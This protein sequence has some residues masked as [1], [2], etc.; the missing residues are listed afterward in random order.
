MP[1]RE[2]SN[3]SRE[4][5]EA[6]VWRL[7]ERVRTGSID[8]ARQNAVFE[9]ALDFAIVVTDREGT[10]TDWNSGSEHVMGW[11]AE[12]MRGQDAARFFTPEDRANGRV[13][14]EMET[15]LKNGRAQDER[16][17]LKQGEERF[18]ASGEMMPLRDDD[19]RHIGFVK[20]MR[21]RTAEHMAG[22]A[23]RAGELRR[24]ALLE[25]SDQ[26]AEHDRDTASLADVASGI[27]GRALGVQ[28][29]GYG[30]VDP[31][32]ETIDVERDWT[33]DGAHS[34]AGSL[35]FRDF[36]SYIDDIKRGETVVIGDARIDPRTSA[37]ADALEAISARAF[38]NTPVVEHGRLVSLLF[39]CSATPRK[40]TKDEL[41][42]I[43]EVAA[44]TRTATARKQAESAL[45]AREAELRLVADA[46]PVLVAFIDRTLTYRFVNAACQWWFGRAPDT[47]VGRTI[48]DLL[49]ES[50]L[51]E[52]RAGIER[53][54]AGET[55]QMDLDWP[56]SDGRR[57]IAAIRYTPRRDASGSVD[58]F[59]VFAQDVTDLRDATAL[60]A[61]RADTLAHEVAERT[62]ERDRMWET[63]PDLMLEI[64]FDG[65]FQRVNPAWTRLLGYAPDELVGHHVNEFVLPADHTETTGA[66]TQAA[67][68]GQPRL[69]N[70]YRHKNGSVRWISWSAAPAGRMTY[71]T[72]R[73]ITAEREQ[74]QALE[75]TA[76]ALRQSQKMEAVGQ[77]TGGVA[78]DFNNLLTII[79]SS[80]DFLRRPNLPEERRKRY[81]DAVS[82]TVE[83][84]AKLT[85]QLLAFAR[86]QALKPEVL[87]VGERLRAVADMLDTVTGARVRVVTEL[88]DHPCFIEADVSQFETAL[89]N[90]A[91]NA[92][93]AM[94]GEGT[95]TLRLTCGLPMPPIRGHG[96][97]PGP[98]AKIELS[99]T[100]SGIAEVDLARIFEPFFTTKEVGKGTGLGLSQVFGFAKQSGG[101]VSVRS[102]VGEGT[103]FALYLPEVAAPVDQAN[104]LE[105]TSPAPDGRGLSVLVV[106]DNIE[107]G[108]FATQIL[109][110]LGY[111]TEWAAN[112]EAALER[113]GRDGDGFDAVFSDVV[114]PG[115][116]GIAMAEE[117]RR[118]LPTMPVLLASGY[119]HVLAQN[120]THGFELLHKPYSADQLSRMLRRLIHSH[121]RRR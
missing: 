107:V 57:R 110:D 8:A 56:W 71:A 10:I 121:Q 18:W 48:D 66:Y 36:G 7:R 61:A 72:G 103:T 34:I 15:A 112:A 102:V 95:L 6:E 67:E 91:V 92:R 43:R 98:F 49:G 88:P 24:Q 11:T 37:H 77:L 59:Y 106:E 4:E 38:V 97:G 115:I 51:A 21:D 41:L 90:M 46:L 33:T 39:V 3:L 94:E 5:L 47:V 55:V 19:D 35:R 114:M 29:V 119:S 104:D 93:D 14:Y 31:E 22:V 60:L 113:L 40:W 101:D 28:L 111:R 9:S 26:L 30:L 27:L 81:M 96:G 86:R 42:F 109:E 108:K 53:A 45:L 75:A 12:E 82:D 85:G 74:A 13:T 120:S 63:S 99:D 62:V 83:R 23:L 118:R 25:L 58:G 117:L 69:V 44:R 64:D 116:G 73:D 100:G 68:G 54:L 32:T 17:H 16:W 1:G 105:E 87:S 89:V 70:R 79:R 65:V 84:A 80:V 78:H 52:R 50:G 20:I 76:E 2:L